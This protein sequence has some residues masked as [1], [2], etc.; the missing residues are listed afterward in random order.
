MKRYMIEM[1]DG[2]TPDF[3]CGLCLDKSN[4]PENCSGLILSN[5]KEAKLL[6]ARERGFYICDDGKDPVTYMGKP[7][8][9]WATEDK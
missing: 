9:L 3:W 1:P 5:A 8:K 4:C 2:I 6:D 7:V